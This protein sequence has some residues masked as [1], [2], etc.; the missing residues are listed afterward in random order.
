MVNNEV[1]MGDQP[2]QCGIA[3]QYF[4]GSP[5]SIVMGLCDECYVCTLY[6]Y[7]KLSFVPAQMAW[8]MVGRQTD[9]TVGLVSK[10]MFS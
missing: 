9:S 3:I 1:L 2:C 7:T 5:V 4:R 8:G 6:S 10:G